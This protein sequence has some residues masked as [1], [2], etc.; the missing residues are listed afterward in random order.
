MAP[1]FVRGSSSTP[2]GQDIV[3]IGQKN[4]NLYALAAETGKVFWAT[5]TSP[6]GVQGGLIWGIAVDASN[7]YYTAVNSERITW[8]LKNGT[9]FSG[10]AFGAASLATGEIIWDT[11][12]PRNGTSV[13]MPS[14]VNDVVLNGVGGPYA[15]RFNNVG[16]GSLV[17]LDKHTGA[18]IKET[19]LETYFQGGIAIVQDYVLFGTS[20]QRLDNG[21]FNVLKLAN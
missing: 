8:K 20:Y 9:E 21:S 13:V 16:P 7:A 6:D 17:A 12:V 1:S 15:G 19:V 5:A 11:A 4:G 10:A 14:V 3:V 18:I 2:S